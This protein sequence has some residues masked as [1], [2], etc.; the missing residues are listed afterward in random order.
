MQT[1]AVRTEKDARRRSKE[2]K[3][4]LLRLT[5]ALHAK[6]RDPKKSTEIISDIEKLCPRN[7]DSDEARKTW[8]Y[9]DSEDSVLR[10]LD[11][12]PVPSELFG[13]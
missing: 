13:K 11:N 12:R 3:H 8:R 5:L 9:I 1:L 7:E 4:M 2:L 6:G 10:E